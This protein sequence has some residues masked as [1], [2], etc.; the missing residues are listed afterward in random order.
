MN[1]IMVQESTILSIN[2]ISDFSIKNTQI[3]IDSFLDQLN[4]K[5]LE[6]DTFTQ[7]LELLYDNL[8]DSVLFYTIEEAKQVY[9]ALNQAIQNTTFFV[10]NQLIASFDKN[11]RYFTS[12]TLNRLQ[13]SISNLK[14]ILTDLEDIQSSIEVEIDE[15]TENEILAKVQDIFNG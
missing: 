14:E 15:D 9:G 4:A 1:S 5:A 6:L 12:L 8:L 3:H 11:E 13:K 7:N 10:M 2:E